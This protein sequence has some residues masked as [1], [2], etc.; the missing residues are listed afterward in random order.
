VCTL[1]TRFFLP[2]FLHHPWS[3][4]ASPEAQQLCFVLTVVPVKITKH[5]G[6]GWIVAEVGRDH[7]RED[8]PTR[9]IRFD[10]RDGSLFPS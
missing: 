3:C 1:Y 2:S 4:R 7:R 6:L 5:R 9:R 10:G 8:G